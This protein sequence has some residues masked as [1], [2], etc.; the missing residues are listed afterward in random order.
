MA[1]SVF[2]IAGS[3]PSRWRWFFVLA[4]VVVAVPSLV[5]LLVVFW[6]DHVRFEVTPA[7]LKVRGS[8]Y[9]RTIPA[10]AIRVEG[11]R[12]LSIDDT[13][14]IY[15]NRRTNGIGLPD[16]SAGWFELNDGRS[17]LLFVTDW[18][19]TIVVPTT[20]GYDLVLSPDDPDALVAAVKVPVANSA[21][22][23]FPLAK[24]PARGWNAS[25]LIL[26]LL[27]F[28]LP[29]VLSLAALALLMNAGRRVRFELSGDALRIRGDLYGRT[30]PRSDLQVA[31][32]S[33]IDMNAHPTFGRM[34]RTNGIG[35]PNY[36][37]G[38]FRPHGGGR[39]LLFVTDRARV[40]AVPTTAG[41]H[42]LISP[43]DA[44]GFLAA[45]QNDGQ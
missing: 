12:R 14:G 32:A 29:P 25:G 22:R 36:L 31:H 3:S 26:T 21:L 13:P 23:T 45:L 6:P 20:S 42:L 4:A 38:W 44:D 34:L 16:Y 35:M 24:A 2:P 39:A 40:V 37:S 41:Y 1:L 5:A 9:G 28:I 33:V 30:I 19:R 17:A 10:A 27:G 15:P 11:T 7:G 18:S 8:L 43:A